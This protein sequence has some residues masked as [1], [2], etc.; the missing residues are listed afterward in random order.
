MATRM[1]HEMSYEA[2]ID[3]VAAMLS[4]RVF[5]EE[6]CSN[7]Q[8]T[9]HDV[10]I[11]GDVSAKQVRIEM[12]QPTDRVPSFA[13]K[14]IGETTTIV[15]SESWSS[16]TQAEVTIEIPGKPGDIRGTA[17]LAEVDGVTTE[18]VDLQVKVKIP[19]VAGKIEELLAKLVRSALKAEHRTGQAWLTR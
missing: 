15:Q 2:P 4:D 13:K 14:F 3:A 10:S 12:V 16:P 8:A 7:Q 19:L 17:T 6:V 9:S 5:R 11:D 18:T 1:L